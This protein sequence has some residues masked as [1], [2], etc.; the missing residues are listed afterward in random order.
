MRLL[1]KYLSMK[2]SKLKT[3]RT[4][5]LRNT[6]VSKVVRVRMET[7]NYKVNSRCE[8]IYTTRLDNRPISGTSVLNDSHDV[9]KDY[10]SSFLL[11]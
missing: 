2:R 5:G 1:F 4:K 6:K 9:R 10:K 8:Q 3:L 7:L 11:A